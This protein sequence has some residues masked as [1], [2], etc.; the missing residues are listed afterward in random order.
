[1]ECKNARAMA[2]L[3]CCCHTDRWEPFWG[4]AA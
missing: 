3:I 4:R 2:A 1:M